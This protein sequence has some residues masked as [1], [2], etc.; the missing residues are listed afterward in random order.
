MP[1]LRNAR[2]ER[3]AQELAQGK[4]AT[5]AME[6]AGIKDARNSTRLTKNDEIRRRIDELQAP[7]VE[8][9]EITVSSLIEEADR[10]L[11][12]AEQKEQY[13]AAIAGLKLKSIYAGLYVEKAESKV[14]TTE[15]TIERSPT[16][17]D[18][19]AKHA[20]EEEDSR[21]A[22]AGGPSTRTH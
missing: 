20:A 15:H 18:W 1:I 16:A 5:E 10:L 19:Q 8:K 17:N 14:E 12:G 22:A 7:A 13:S 3:F 21:L 4:T 2:H 9:A 6:L 11:Q